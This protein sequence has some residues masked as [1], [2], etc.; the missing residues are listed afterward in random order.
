MRFRFQD[1]DT[2]LSAEFPILTL[3]ALG[4][5]VAVH[6]NNRSPEP[7]DM[8]PGVVEAFYAAYRHFVTLLES[9]RYQVRFKLEPGDLFIVDNLRVLHGRTGFSAAGQRR[10]QGCYADRDSLRSKLAVLSRSLPAKAAMT[11]DDIINAIFAKF[12]EYGQGVYLGEP[13]TLTEHMLQ[14]AY[15]AEQDGAGPALIAA[16]VVHDFGHFVHDLDEDSAQHGVDTVHEEAGAAYL[17]RYF[18][19][20]VVE[21]TRLH[22][23]AKRYLCAVD[24]A[25]FDALSPASI[26]SLKLQ[27]GPLDEAGVKAYEALPFA[28]VAAR[29]RRYDDQGKTPGLRTPDLEHYRPF[30]VAGLKPDLP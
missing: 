13:V 16:A 8:P 14:T 25:Y 1:E 10:L 22:V 12:N 11:H 18:I 7:F 9:P 2:D 20:A 15:A 5:L 19:P 27:G 29:L 17:S 30:L 3:N 21:P 23:A 24:P 4:E 26:L 28:Q 6:Y